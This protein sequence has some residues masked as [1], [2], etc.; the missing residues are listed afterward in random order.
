LKAMAKNPAERYASAQELADDLKRFLEDKPIRARRPTLLERATK[1][2]R[3]HRSIVVA[4]G[5]VLGRAGIGLGGRT[6]RSRREQTPRGGAGMGCRPKWA[7]NGWTRNR[8]WKRYRGGF[9]SKRSSSTR[10]SPPSKGVT[11]R[12]V[13]RRRRLTAGSG[14]FSRSWGSAQKQR[15]PTAER[16]P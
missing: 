13:W 7:K 3:R 5:G 2:S 1:W 8:T 10:S 16:S 14:T 12:S 9:C 6:G 15:K 4:G 11:R